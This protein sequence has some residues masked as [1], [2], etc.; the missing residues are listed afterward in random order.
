MKRTIKSM[1]KNYELK[2]LDMV[3]TAFTDYSDAEEGL[4][5]TELIQEIRGMDTHIPELELI[6]IDEGQNEVIGYVMFSKF[7]LEGR[8]NDELLLLS[9]A[10]VKTEY[11]RQHI[12][13]E[14]IEYGF[15][16]ATELGFKAV[17]VEGN[18]AN[19]RSRG[20]VTAADYGIFP[21][22]S[23]DLPALECLMV[24]ELVPGALEEIHGVVEYT[25]YHT[26]NI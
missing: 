22:K 15:Q 3:K 8:Y 14:Q 24:K 1:N 18:P 12:S 20:F 17:I 6:M 25:A 5:V 4:L 11:Q 2:A 13:K 7:H 16:K 9:P 19:Y 10:A 23:V 26:L 21:G